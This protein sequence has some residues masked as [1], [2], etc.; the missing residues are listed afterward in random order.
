MVVPQGKDLRLL[1][2]FSDALQARADEEGNLTV[3][4]P[5]GEKISDLK[6]LTEKWGIRWRKTHSASDE[7][8]RALEELAARNTGHAQP[9][10]AGLL[11]VII[12]ESS[13]DKVVELA[14]A[15]Q[16]LKEMEYVELVSADRPVPPPAADILPST[17]DLTLLQTYRGTDFG[18][19]VDY[20]WNTLGVRGDSGLR[21]TDC[22]YSFNPQ[23]EDLKDLVSL[24][25]G[26]ESMYSGF[27]DS[28]GTAVLGILFGGD[29]GYGISGAVPECQG[30]FCPEYAQ[31][32]SGDMQYRSASIA[33]A[34][35][36][37]QPGDIVLLE[38]QTPAK[39]GADYVP[40]EFDLSVWTLV[41]TATDAGIIVV[42]A[43]G[44]GGQNLDTSFFS[45]YR[46]RGDSGAI[47]V[48]AGNSS[49]AHLDFS[50]YGTRVNLQG[51]G[52]K[53]A[54]TGYG[55]YAR[56]GDDPN[57]TYTVS[58]GGT[59][60]AA[61]MAAS[62]AALLQAVAIQ[63]NGVR[64]TPVEM[65]N[66]LVSTGRQ[67]TGDMSRPIGKLPNL[68]DAVPALFTPIVILEQP[69][70]QAVVAGK[71]VTLSVRAGSR[72]DL[73]YQW[74]KGGKDIPGATAA[75]FS[76]PRVSAEDAGDYTV[77]VSC[78]QGA[79]ESEAAR[80]WFSD[81]KGRPYSR[82]P[83]QIQTRGAGT[84]S[85]GLAGKT[86]PIGAALTI[87]A[88]PAKGMIFKEWL[89]NG[90]P[91]S[92]SP[93]LS[94]T[95]EEGLILEA[96][97]VPNPYPAATGFFNGLLGEGNLGTGS[98]ADREAFFHENGFVQMTVRSDGGFT[99]ALRLE[100]KS[101]PFS[102]RFDGFGE[103][104][105]SLKRTGRSPID[106]SVT[107]DVTLP[108]IHGT[109]ASDGASIEFS[110]LRGVY[111]GTAKNMHPLAGRRYTI[112][113]PDDQ[114]KWGNG[115][116]TVSI[117]PNGTA[118]LVGTLADS[119][120]FSTSARL[121]SRQEDEWILPV[122][123]PIYSKSEGMIF[124]ELSFSQEDAPGLPDAAGRL[125]WLS[126]GAAGFLGSLTAWGEHYQLTRNLSLVGG[127]AV[128][129]SCQLTFDPLK[130]ILPSVAILHGVW[131][132]SNVPA[133][134]KSDSK[135]ATWSFMPTTGVFR[136]NLVPGVAGNLSSAAF[137]GV[138]F[139]HSLDLPGAGPVHGGG[140]FRIQGQ[141]GEMNIISP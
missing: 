2:K 136:G 119:T 29:N 14:A 63:K 89:K 86:L 106:V 3:S 42:A 18:I 137:S 21:I 56:Y 97:F 24:Q 133:L 114:G 128:P 7:K 122:Q 73:A 23:H 92:R 30:S 124:G 121:T 83:L 94:F 28:H 132:A 34:V 105:I 54:S 88:T 19:G 61:P 141:S 108:E 126:P 49:R 112:L 109:V 16:P 13:R 39:N 134:E 36:E 93:R 99:G 130:K 1:V 135:L 41:K 12:P 70:G 102:G 131:P 60:S 10:L 74:R 111:S 90:V 47:I 85:G 118:S 75:K 27:G 66:L 79:V 67:Q 50:T 115:F 69:Q 11:E 129:A 77:M 33:K 25:D 6:K 117:S 84:F 116:A 17:P 38:M 98:G 81:S 9:D 64:L 72:F 51:W 103:A 15:L 100:G 4:L 123:V 78:A 91:F 59:S 40:A 95:M 113:L 104:E 82:Q 140:F 22:E 31:L 46:N 8:L 55:Y 57:Q 62:A 96:V 87:T 32:S 101:Q 5:R 43:A 45:A 138:M 139:S 44:N 20:V 65:R 53:V 76:I 127:G 120:Y 68:V 35:T 125:A 110:A 58:F 52:E 26:V 107:L 80:L 71:S 48:G 37:S